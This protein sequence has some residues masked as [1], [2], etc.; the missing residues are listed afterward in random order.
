M[1][2]R[3]PRIR[4]FGV[5]VSVNLTLR[6]IHYACV[7]GGKDSLFMLK[8][9]LSNPNKYPLDM[10]VHYQLEIDWEWAERTVD[11]M[12]SECKKYGINFLR[13]KP[14]KSWHEI[15]KTRFMPTGKVRWCNKEYKMDAERQIRKWIKEQNCRPIAYIGFCADETRRFK[16]E[17]GEWKDQDICYPLAE[18]GINE[19]EVLIWARTVPLFNDWYKYFKRQG[20]M[21]CPMLSRLELAYLCV[22]YP[23]KYVEYIGYVKEYEDKF[24]K[25]WKT[26][27]WA[28][29]LDK[30]IRNK[31]VRILENKMSY[32][33]VTID[34]WLNGKES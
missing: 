8:V 3:L 13:I 21:M 29:D 26:G 23:G 24:G 22:Y 9:I 20:C 28:D 16:Y 10:V 1:I 6:P 33:Q 19:S 15:Y 31:W 32:E 7:S 11:Y 18:E 27:L 34:Q 17:I 30:L 4:I 5:V 12:E 25:Q 2:A 14:R